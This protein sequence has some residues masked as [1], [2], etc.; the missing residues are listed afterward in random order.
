[1][2]ELKCCPFCQNTSL[3]IKKYK[4]WYYIKCSECMSCG[5]LE[6]TEEKAADSWNRRG[7]N[8][9]KRFM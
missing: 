7:N 1:M 4:Y 8:Y 9:E 5:P 6:S 3:S 2:I